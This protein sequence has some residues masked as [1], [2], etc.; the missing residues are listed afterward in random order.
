MVS[1]ILPAA[2][3]DLVTVP[4]RLDPSLQLEAAFIARRF[5]EARGDDQADAFAKSP[6]EDGPGRTAQEEDARGGAS[7]AK[8]IAAKQ[9]NRD[10]GAS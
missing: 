9:R 8:L 6:A 4:S 5:K 2:V 3:A 1:A 10:A 7:S